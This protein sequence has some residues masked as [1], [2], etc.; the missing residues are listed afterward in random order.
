MSDEEGQEPR[1]E[2]GND[3][4]SVDDA[5]DDV[6]PRLRG[7]FEAFGQQQRFLASVDFSFLG[8][9][10]LSLSQLPALKKLQESVAK[11]ISQSIH[12]PA[13]QEAIQS[14][15]IP[16]ITLAAQLQSKFAEDLFKAIDFPAI[17]RANA[18]VVNSGVLFDATKLQRET[19][20]AI[21]PQVD[22]SALT[23]RFTELFKGFD[24]QAL[25]EG[26]SRWLP[27]NLQDSDDLDE[28]ARICLDEGIP[29]AWVPRAEIVRELA[30][31]SS[32]QERQR[33]LETRFTDIVDD[34]EVA[35]TDIRHEWAVQTRTSVAALR[36]EGLEGPAQSHAAGIIDSIVVTT[37]GGLGG[38]SVAKSKAVEPFDD[39][40]LH[41]VA[42]SL[43]FRPLFLGFTE[44]YP[45][46]GTPIPPTFARHPTAHAIG[47]P[48][49]FTR[50]KAL[51]G[52]MLA[53]S[54]TVQFWHDPLAPPELSPPA[55]GDDGK[56]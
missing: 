53:T 37:Q 33:I 31:A 21:G 5:D 27:E 22:Y 26:F 13:L 18:L 4:D 3:T 10:Q 56:T 14:I 28:V 12:F 36:Q 24:W 25:K 1:E 50:L 47:Q 2:D 23:G 8:A 52:V 9:P 39:V 46:R 19:L 6:E 48:D 32:P 17:E 30:A 35:L 38:R 11:S 43:V 44:W 49:V 41:F 34:C 7:A 16:Q 42:E 45:N 20:A 51:I 40:P 54:L 29:L 15:Q 55:T